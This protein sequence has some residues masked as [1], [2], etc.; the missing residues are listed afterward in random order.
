M[1]SRFVC[2]HKTRDKISKVQWTSRKVLHIE[3]DSVQEDPS[4]E[5]WLKGQ[6]GQFTKAVSCFLQTVEVQTSVLTFYP[7]GSSKENHNGL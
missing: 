7:T 5:F 4:K 2:S 3:P 1:C 6:F